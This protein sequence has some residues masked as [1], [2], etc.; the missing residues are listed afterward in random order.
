M[1][2]PS[3]EAEEAVA[4]SL[5]YQ[6]VSRSALLTTYKIES[7]AR[8]QEK[9][10]GRWPGNR[11]VSEPDPRKIGRWVWETGWGRSVPSGMYGICNY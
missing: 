5:H 7:Y 3:I 4:S 2:I 8:G 9:R 11:V 1:G 10:S 6:A